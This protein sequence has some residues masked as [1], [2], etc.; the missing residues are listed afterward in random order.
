MADVMLLFAFLVSALSV[1]CVSAH[2]PCCC[3]GSVAHSCCG[4][5]PGSAGCHW[6]NSAATGRIIAESDYTQT[7]ETDACG[8]FTWLAGSYSI[9][10]TFDL[11]IDFSE[12]S[13]EPCEFFKSFHF[14]PIYSG[15][16]S[17]GVVVCDLME[18]QVVSQRTVFYSPKPT[19]APVG[20][21]WGVDAGPE[22]N[23]HVLPDGVVFVG[24]NSNFFDRYARLTSAGAF[25][26]PGWSGSMEINTP[27]PSDC[28]AS[29]EFTYDLSW[30]NRRY[31][32]VVRAA[33]SPVRECRHE[34]PEPVFP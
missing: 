24:P 26:E 20:F 33:V 1:V 2:R 14:N 15:F 31:F 21:L 18:Q 5:T 6:A 7:R 19:G 22:L 3:T 4:P 28:V 25:F 9:D 32:G 34:Q 10:E 17:P 27:T 8:V 30:F 11:P 13:D 23:V 16:N 29:F 12:G